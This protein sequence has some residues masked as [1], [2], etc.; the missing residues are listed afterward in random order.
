MTTTDDDPGAAP[1]PDAIISSSGALVCLSL[2]MLIPSL[3]ISITN[4]ALPVFAA[5]FAISGQAA[6]WVVLAHL[7]AVT[8][9]VVTAGRLGDLI[10]RRTLLL[11]GLLLF[12]GASLACA[13]A[14][15]FW[16]LVAARFL[17]G[18]G[19][20][21]LTALSMAF[22]GDVVPKERMGSAMGLLGTMSAVGTALGPALG[23]AL[24]ARFGWSS[25]FLVNVPLGGVAL[26]TAWLFLRRADAPQI[27]SR[28]RFDPPGILLL[29]LALGCHS[30]SMTV[31]GGDLGRSNILLLLLAAAFAG[32]FVMVERASPAPLVRLD[33]FADTRLCASFVAGMLVM[34]VVMATLVVG[35]FYLSDAL[36]LDALELGLVMSSGPIAAALTGVPAGRLVDRLGASRMSLIALSAAMSG[37]CAFALASSGGGVAAYVGCLVVITSGYALFQ[38]ANNTFALKDAPADQR[39][40]IS[41]LLTLSRNLGLVTGA[42]AMG[43]LYAIA[44]AAYRDSMQGAAASAAAMRI[45][46]LAGATLIGVAML[47]LLAARRGGEA[48]DH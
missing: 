46:F 10:G 23:G 3:S 48:N 17:Q 13:V 39:G 11:Y 47:V 38:A 43:G 42:S 6:Q 35:P 31:G 33:L 2:C 19:A 7:L 22:V 45:T 5:T 18:V 40:V 29:A 24:I 27:P 32:A 41:G 15:S 1:K 37:A 36:G 9:L 34:T 26:A 14:P 28:P 8:T 12:T 30:L 44:F 4:V 25:I 16:F 21:V 20:A